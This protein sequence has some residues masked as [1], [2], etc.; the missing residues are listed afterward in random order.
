MLL[1]RV[2]SQIQFGEL[3]QIVLGDSGGLGLTSTDFP[4]VFNYIN[5]GLTDL[6]TRFPLRQDTVKIQQSADRDI[7]YLRTRYAQSNVN[8]TEPVKYLV[9]AD[10]P[11]TGNL[12]LIDRVV[13]LGV[14]DPYKV[15]VYPINDAGN[16]YN[17]RTPMMDAIVP[18]SPDT[19][20]ILEVTF[21]ANHPYVNKDDYNEETTEI[22]LPEGF[23]QALICF[24]AAKAYTPMGLD[25]A[26][27]E[28]NL[29]WARYESECAKL[30][31]FGITVSTNDTYDR[32]HDNGWV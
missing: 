12:L 15:S 10:K 11:F 1:S 21:R 13:D 18:P 32:L 20:S 27:N 29:Y 6:H 25:G 22:D 23:L 30:S 8:S 7:Y 19:E 26:K 17:V 2:I 24:I 5:L 16:I 31:H 28:S 4:A 14:T 9:D 3:S